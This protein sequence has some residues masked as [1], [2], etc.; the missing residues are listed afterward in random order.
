MPG[1]R[2]WD[3]NM[4]DAEATLDRDDKLELEF[5][6]PICAMKGDSIATAINT[7]DFSKVDSSNGAKSTRHDPAAARRADS[8]NTSGWERL[9]DTKIPGKTWDYRTW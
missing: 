1:G 3:P 2:D 5:D 6:T 8:D 9:D 4:S 7:R